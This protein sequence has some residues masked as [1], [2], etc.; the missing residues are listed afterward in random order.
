VGVRVRH[1]ATLSGTA[2]RPRLKA[3]QGRGAT[4]TRHTTAVKVA[5]TRQGRAA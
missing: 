3:P 5:A 2:R 1:T 4:S